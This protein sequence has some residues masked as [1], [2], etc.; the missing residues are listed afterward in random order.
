MMNPLPRELAG[1]RTTSPPVS[2]QNGSKPIGTR[3]RTT[4]VVEMLTTDAFVFWTT[5]TV[6]VRR[7]LIVSGGSFAPAVVAS[8]ETRHAARAKFPNVLTMRDFRNHHALRGGRPSTPPG[9]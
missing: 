4:F 5:S 8:A 9:A 1:T 3:R 6:T 7:R 2:N